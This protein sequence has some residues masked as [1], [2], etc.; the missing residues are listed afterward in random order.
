MPELPK[1]AFDVIDAQAHLGYFPGH[2]NYHISA[3]ELVRCL[4]AEGVSF[5]LTS[6][7]S[8][9]TISPSFGTQEMLAAA[10]KYPDRL[11]TLVWINPRDPDWLGV[12]DNAVDH[13]ALG[14][15][16]HPKIDNYRVDFDSLRD[17]FAFAQR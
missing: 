17:V 3:E 4:D 16:L 14:I 11:G 1:F 15:K 7:A 5:A 10:E 2:V 13:G 9:T 8:S 6:S 12:S